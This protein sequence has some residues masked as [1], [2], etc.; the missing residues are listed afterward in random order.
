MK[1]LAILILLAIAASSTAQQENTSSEPS[2]KNI[3]VV[4]ENVKAFL[5]NDLDR[6]V[7]YDLMSDGSK[8]FKDTLD[9]N[10]YRDK[11]IFTITQNQTILNRQLW[12]TIVLLTTAI[13]MLIFLI[14]R[15]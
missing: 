10:E 13:G 9:F 1:R 5:E 15:K 4:R 7:V 8:V 2:D 6:Y 12:A 3:Q 14:R 11:A